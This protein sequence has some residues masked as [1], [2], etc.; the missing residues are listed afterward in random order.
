MSSQQVNDMKTLGSTEHMEAESG[1]Q[2]SSETH[3]S[4]ATNIK[5]EMG[6]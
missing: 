2:Y 1:S 5:A 4:L 3:Q 6:R